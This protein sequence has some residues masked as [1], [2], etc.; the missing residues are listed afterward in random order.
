MKTRGWVI[1]CADDQYWIN[2]DSDLSIERADARV[3]LTRGEAFAA[4]NDVCSKHCCI[5][6]R[7]TRRTKP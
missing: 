1:R 2:E 3:F 5:V 7:L 6:Y 4:R